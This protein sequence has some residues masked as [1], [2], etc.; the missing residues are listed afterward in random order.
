MPNCSKTAFT[1]HHYWVWAFNTPPKFNAQHPLDYDLIIVD[2]VSMIDLR[3]ASQLVTA[4]APQSRLILL[5]DANQ[6]KRQ[7]KQE[8][9]ARRNW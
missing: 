4:I 1:L 5:G 9:Y 6:L 8:R 3:M 2:E 7:S